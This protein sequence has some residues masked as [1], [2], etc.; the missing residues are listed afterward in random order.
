MSVKESIFLKQ[1][2]HCGAAL[3]VDVYKRSQN[4][5]LYNY[6]SRNCIYFLPKYFLKTFE[7]FSGD[8]MLESNKSLIIKVYFKFAA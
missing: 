2:C 7:N 4:E 1:Q 3:E 5:A 8:S 6:F